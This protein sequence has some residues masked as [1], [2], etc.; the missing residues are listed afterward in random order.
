MFQKEVADRILGKVNEKNYGR[1][2]II[3]NWKL[4]IKR[5][6]DIDASAFFP[7]PKVKSTLLSMVPKNNYFKITNAQKLEEIT[8]I[9]FNQRRKMI[10]KPLNKIFNNSERIIK[11]LNIDTNLR[12]QNLKPE[13]YFELAEILNKSTS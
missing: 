12:P 6:F 5:E 4:K 2:S 7:K 11:K 8:S 1:L 13:V 10:K 3:S 9:F